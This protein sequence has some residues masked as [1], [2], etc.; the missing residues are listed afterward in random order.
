MSQCGW[1]RST[2][3][4]RSTSTCCETYWLNFAD[5]GVGED[6]QCAQPQGTDQRPGRHGE[7]EELPVHLAALAAARQHLANYFRHRRELQKYIERRTA[8]GNRSGRQ[9]LNIEMTDGNADSGKRCH[10][11]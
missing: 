3:S 5:A 6:T 7:P 2:S 11:N 4:T 9:A 1:R 10:S 8:R